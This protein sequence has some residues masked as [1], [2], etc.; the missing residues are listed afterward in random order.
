MKARKIKDTYQ[1]KKERKD[2]EP[3]QTVGRTSQIASSHKTNQVV[4]NS[5][6]FENSIRSNEVY[7]QERCWKIRKT[8]DDDD[9]KT[10]TRTRTVKKKEKE[11]KGKERE[12][13]NPRDI[14]EV[15][16]QEKEELGFIP[17][18]YRYSQ[19]LSLSSEFVRF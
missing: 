2:I 1:K 5:Q 19:I 10:G 3:G 9:E 4:Q 18:S 14:H 12:N 13:R 17:V 8:D 7:I 6:L 11:K 16:P 15:W